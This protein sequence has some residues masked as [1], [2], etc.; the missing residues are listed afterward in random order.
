[1]VSSSL[2][3]NQLVKEVNT[4]KKEDVQRVSEDMVE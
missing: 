1:M 3:D 4:L 2:W